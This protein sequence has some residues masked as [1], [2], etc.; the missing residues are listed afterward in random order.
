VFVCVVRVWILCKNWRW[1]RLLLQKRRREC[2]AGFQRRV[3]QSTGL[4]ADVW[5]GGM[6]SRVTCMDVELRRWSCKCIHSPELS[7]SCFCIKSKE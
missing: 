5:V 7:K 3:Q 6:L 2:V 1:C 4:G